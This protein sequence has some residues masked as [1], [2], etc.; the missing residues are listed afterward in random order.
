MGEKRC[1]I[2]AARGPQ[3]ALGA[4]GRDG[5]EGVG[6]A[7]DVEGK[8]GGEH[9]PGGKKEQVRLFKGIRIFRP[10]REGRDAVEEENEAVAEAAVNAEE[11]SRRRDSAAASAYMSAG[12]KPRRA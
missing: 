11:A 5:A 1:P 7:Q 4:L 2:R 3:P 12:A 8:A 10:S 9:G 6:V